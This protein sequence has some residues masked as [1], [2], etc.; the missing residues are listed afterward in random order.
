[1]VHEL[2]TV[3]VDDLLEALEGAVNKV[4]AVA[5]SKVKLPSAEL[6]VLTHL[7]QVRDVILG[8][9]LGRLRN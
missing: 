6:N 4:Q 7:E 2:T 5:D 9:L 3:D 1:M 8:L